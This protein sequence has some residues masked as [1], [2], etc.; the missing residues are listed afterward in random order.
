MVKYSAYVRIADDMWDDVPVCDSWAKHELKRMA[1]ED[2][3]DVEGEIVLT[4]LE[5]MLGTDEKYIRA[6][7]IVSVPEV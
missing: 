7:A 4:R 2:G 5:S 6:S 1:A 3:C